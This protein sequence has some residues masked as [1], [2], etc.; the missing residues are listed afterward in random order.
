[1]ESEVEGLAAD[2]A[3]ATFGGNDCVAW[4]HMTDIEH[5]KLDQDTSLTA[6]MLKHSNSLRLLDQKGLFFFRRRPR[7]DWKLRVTLDQFAENL[8]SMAAV[9][10]QQQ[11]QLILGLWPGRVQVEKPASEDEGPVMTRRYAKY[12]DVVRSVARELELPCA[13]LVTAMA[14][15]RPAS[16]EGFADTVHANPMGNELVASEFCRIITNMVAQP[17]K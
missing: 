4:D 6:A 7:G 5:A 8:R 12:Q 17:A 15:A 1:M 14:E 2:I 13:D 11:V 9:C 10:E 16:L 3:I